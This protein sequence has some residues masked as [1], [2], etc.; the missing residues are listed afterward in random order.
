MVPRAE[1]VAGQ[2]IVG[3]KLTIGVTLRDNHVMV[4]LLR[5]DGEQLTDERL[6]AIGRI[7]PVMVIFDATNNTFGRFPSEVPRD[8]RTW[9]DLVRRV[10]EDE[11]CPPAAH[12]F[13]RA[14]QGM[15]FPPIPTATPVL[16]APRPGNSGSETHIGLDG[17]I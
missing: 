5:W 7:T 9:A 12:H 2:T 3:W 17:P 11:S 4:E 1:Q 13:G 8:L 6:E 16:P 10:L 14:G 15:D